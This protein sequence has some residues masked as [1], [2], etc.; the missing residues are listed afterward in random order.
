MLCFVIS[1]GV[2][3]SPVF[4]CCLYGR[5]VGGSGE[6]EGLRAD[7]LFW[8]EK[9][10]EKEQKIYITLENKS[11]LCVILCWLASPDQR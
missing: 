2:I 8:K 7:C 10:K 5:V 9:N 6:G 3:V 11:L 1:L 4:S